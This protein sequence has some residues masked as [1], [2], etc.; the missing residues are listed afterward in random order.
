MC[1]SVSGRCLLASWVGGRSGNRGQ[2]TSPCR[3][4]WTV[5]GKPAGTPLSM[6]DLGLVNRVDDLRAAGVRCLKIEGR[7]KSPAWVRAA[8]SLYRM[9]LDGIG[10]RED[11]VREAEALGAYTGRQLTSGYLDSRRDQLTGVSGRERAGG[12]VPEIEPEQP[13]GYSLFVEVG[14]R[15]VCRWSWGDAKVEFDFSRAEVRRAEKA[16]SVGALLDGMSRE[17]IDGVPARLETND[18]SALLV[19][20]TANALEQRVHAEVRR[21]LRGRK[22]L[23]APVRPEVAKVI[24]GASSV[25]LRDARA[26]RVRLS[27]DQV[28]AFLSRGRARRRP[29]RG[30]RRGPP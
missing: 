2:C 11:L 21:A 3:V 4:P 8:V 28:D 30:P 19:P 23:E 25:K 27:V 6:H 14:K 5:D 18:R 24:E 15:L 17:P 10:A 29:R 7:L 9:A 20:R 26:D 16:V 22:L 13:S 12:V 1:F